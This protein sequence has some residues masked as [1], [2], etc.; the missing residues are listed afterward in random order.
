MGR[1]KRLHGDFQELTN[2]SRIEPIDRPDEN[3]SAPEYR[4]MVHGH[5]FDRLLSGDNLSREHGRISMYLSNVYVR[6]KGVLSL[7]FFFAFSFS[8]VK[9]NFKRKRITLI[10]SFTL[11]ST[12]RNLFTKRSTFHRWR[13]K[14]K[15][16]SFS[17]PFSF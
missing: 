14:T 13:E 2:R 4:T 8:T 6:I 7:P 17:R 12:G 5:G 10:S 15:P 11:I 3:K 16:S 9:L 1:D